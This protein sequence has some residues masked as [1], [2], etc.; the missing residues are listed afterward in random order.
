ME[1]RRTGQS[2][3]QCFK[4]FPGR[5]RGRKQSAVGEAP[6]GIVCLYGVIVQRVSIAG[7]DLVEFEFFPDAA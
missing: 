1:A 6:A 3:R 4:V 7:M 2:G 5:K